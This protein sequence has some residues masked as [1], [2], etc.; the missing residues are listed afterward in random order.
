MWPRCAVRVMTLGMTRN[1]HFQGQ[2]AGGAT[3]GP[4]ET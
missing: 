2:R 4:T 3:T 1:A